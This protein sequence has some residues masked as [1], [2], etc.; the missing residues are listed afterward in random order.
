MDAWTHLERAMKIKRRTLSNAS[1]SR[2]TRKNMSVPSLMKRMRLNGNNKHPSVS[3]EPLIEDE[4]LNPKA[5]PNLAYKYTFFDD[6]KHSRVFRVIEL[7][8]HLNP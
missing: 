3:S 2:T 1:S 4:E 7:F 5:M 6:V 8:R